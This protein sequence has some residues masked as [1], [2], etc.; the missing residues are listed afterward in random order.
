MLSF[1]QINLHKATQATVLV[2][3]S[4]E[5][6][7]NKIVLITE[8]HTVCNKIV[9]MPRGTKLI[10]ARQSNSNIKPRAAI[11][12]SLDT[13]ITAMDGW[14]NEDCAVALVRIRGVQ[15]LVISLYLDINK[16][17][18]P[19]W[20]DNIM[21]MADTK[22]LPIIMGVDSNAHSTLLVQITMPEAMRLRTLSCNM[23]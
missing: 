20:L 19:M 12:A 7:T 13:K 23:D 4:M 17:V 1:T 21:A 8:P 15:T 5:K 2:G 18:Q 3:R 6:C 9:G 14:C 11:M 22:K 16:E 10:Y